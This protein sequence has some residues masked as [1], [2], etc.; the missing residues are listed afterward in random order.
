MSPP[1]QVFIAV[2][3]VGGVGR[4]FLSQL[5][6]LSSRLSQSQTS[7]TYLSLILLSRSSK[8]LYSKD[9]HPLSFGSW[10]AD[11]QA[12]TLPLLPLDQVADYLGRAP[13]KVVL[14]DNTSSQDVAD[15]YPRFLRKGVSVVTPNKKGFSGSYGLWEDIFAAAGSQG[16]GL[17]FHESSVGAGLPVISTLKE[18][19]DTGDEV[20]K[21]E[22]VFSGTMSFLFNSFAPV[23]GGGGKFSEEVKKAKEL[24]F[25]EPDP[26]DD[27]NGLDVARKLTILARLSGLPIESPTSFPVQS[28]IPKPLESA[29]SGDEFLARLGEY[30]EDI[31]KLKKEAEAE[32]KVIRFV[33]SIDVGRKDVKVGL[34]K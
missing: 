31:E 25:T 24:G 9:F 20:R 12:S 10:E 30:D 16:G 33:G 18:L 26:R 14:V 28:L 15:H 19:V 23:G 22:G 3:G 5:R 11:L 7:P 8:L 21:V 34:E 2:I 13:G 32:G 6:A 29:R 27:L 4:A 1:K 17:I